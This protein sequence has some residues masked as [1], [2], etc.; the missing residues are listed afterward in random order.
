MSHSLCLSPNVAKKIL[1][2]R[3]GR[4]RRKQSGKF[5]K[6]ATSRFQKFIPGAVGS[7]DSV[8]TSLMCFVPFVFFCSELRI[9]VGDESHQ[10]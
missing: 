2:R 8:A 10:R 6:I 4:K 9:H 5:H 7:N 3:Q 1:N